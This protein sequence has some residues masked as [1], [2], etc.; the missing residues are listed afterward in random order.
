MPAKGLVWIGL[1]EHI[2]RLILTVNGIDS[3]LALVNVVLEVVV[4]D[5][6]MFGAWADLRYSCNF[7]HTAVVFKN[8]AVDGWLGAAQLEA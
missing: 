7:D 8:L 1:G 5:V 3:D 4:L 2:G 6:D